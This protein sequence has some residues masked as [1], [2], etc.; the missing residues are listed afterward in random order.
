MTV[1]LNF[2][3]LL[4]YL[5]YLPFVY[6]SMQPPRLISSEI[7]LLVLLKSNSHT[8]A[9]VGPLT[10][11]F[12]VVARIYLGWHILRQKEKHGEFVARDELVFMAKYLK[13]YINIGVWCLRS[14]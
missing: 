12:Y 13:Y 6:I 10:V 1:A 4:L 14:R 5:A 11:L 7:A 3:I 8:H 9:M 2:L